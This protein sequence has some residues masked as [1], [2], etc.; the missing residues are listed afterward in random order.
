MVYR[1]FFFS[2]SNAE[3]Q[4]FNNPIFAVPSNVYIDRFRIDTVTLPLSYYPVGPNNN[5][6]SYLE[7]GVAK[8]TNLPEGVYDITTI[9]PAIKTALGALYT[10]TLDTITRKIRITTASTP[11]SILPGNSGTSAYRILGSSKTATMATGINQLLPN[12]VDMTNNAPLLLTSTSLS[13][14]H[15]TF[16]GNHNSNILTVIPVD[17]PVMSY[18]TFVNASGYLECQQNLSL[19]DFSLLDSAT[20]LPIDLRGQPYYIK[21]TVLTDQD[22]IAPS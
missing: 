2:S 4:N 3:N 10:V 15:I 1:E 12:V 7:N 6:I 14:P 22:D 5:K 16:A 8:T 18:S 13:S 20:M 19:I 11:F 9:G 17:R 21:M